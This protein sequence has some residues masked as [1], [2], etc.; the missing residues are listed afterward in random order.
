MDTTLL[1]DSDLQRN[2]G[3]AAALFDKA[4]QAFEDEAFDSARE[5]A[6]Q[7]WAL[8][9]PTLPAV[10]DAP[11][12]PKYSIIVVT[13]RHSDEVIAALDQF[14]SHAADSDYEV[15]VV[16]TGS[17][18]IETVC[19]V[20]FPKFR[21]VA[22]GMTCGLSTGRTIGGAVARGDYLL[23]FDDDAR[24]GDGCIAS[25]IAAV[26]DNRACAAFGRIAP[27]ADNRGGEVR[28]A[29]IRNDGVSIW[30]RDV[31][32]RCGG[33]DSFLDSDAGRLLSLSLY[34]TLGPTAFLYAPSAVL[35]RESPAP[36]SSA[37]QSGD[38]RRSRYIAHA[39]PA[40]AAIAPAL[41]R[42]MDDG[43]QMA[44][45]ASRARYL[46]LLSPD[47]KTKTA[48]SFLTTAR[49]ARTSVAAFSDSL[50]RQ[51]HGNFELVFVDDGSDDGTSEA[52]TAEWKDD[53]RLNLIRSDAEGRAIALNTALAA[54]RHDIC[55]I[56]GIDD[57]AL[58]CRAAVSVAALE[59]YG[60]D[61]V[62]FHLF[63]EKN[64]YLFPEPYGPAT[65]DYR[66]G[67]F[68]GMPAA[69]PALAFRRGK[70]SEPFDANVNGGVACDWLSRN[71]DIREGVMGRVI[72]L[73]AVYHRGGDGRVSAAGRE[74]ALRCVVTCH[75][76]WVGPLD[77]KARK[78]AAVVTGWSPPSAELLPALK[79]YIYR[80]IHATAMYD[81]IA[82]GLAGALL[83][84]L[85]EIERRIAPPRP[86]AGDKPAAEKPP[87]A[88]AKAG[89]TAVPEPEAKAPAPKPMPAKPLK[90]V[91][92]A[93]PEPIQQAAVA[94][95]PVVVKAAPPPPK[96]AVIEKAANPARGFHYNYVSGLDKFDNKA[97][98]EAMTFFLA[99]QE[100]KPE[101]MFARWARAESAIGLGKTGDAVKILT[102]ISLENPNNKKLAKRLGEVA[103]MGDKAT[104]GRPPE[105]SPPQPAVAKAP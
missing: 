27:A 85:H 54:A 33:F 4:K 1:S 14:A 2:R 82:D 52:I 59:G 57:I 47:A 19:K 55:L 84:R 17:P 22:A 61:A 29:V 28:P 50:R 87:Q 101:S 12:K 60:L 97:F 91:T 89:L 62:S 36:L 10:P 42:V 90:P 23:F 39:A 67:R 51:T 75:E 38:D 6:K 24:L 94:P 31:F 88:T 34:R 13:Q 74:T 92:K 98:K 66:V 41:A 49:N 8:L 35:V 45:F 69:F 16:D 71:G 40:C 95:K 79:T 53:P 73:A 102:A 103:D 48:V 99:A 80:L 5:M 11:A 58:P 25:L 37:Q 9:K 43:R 100:A 104:P 105:P 26:V 83:A 70:F 15:I 72:P 21:V 3:E 64:A 18:F 46:N 7:V 65:D 76:A 32:N 20:R 63:D 56:A 77:D 81:D 78:L 68:F 30:R 93:M 86:V 44:A 96:A